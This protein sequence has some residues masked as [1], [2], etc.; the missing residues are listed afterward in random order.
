M[1]TDRVMAWKEGWKKERK[2]REESWRK[3]AHLVSSSLAREM[4]VLKN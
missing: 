2:K 3:K 1:E 4:Q